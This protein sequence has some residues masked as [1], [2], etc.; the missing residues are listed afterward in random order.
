MAGI[1]NSVG[2]WTHLR[3]TWLVRQETVDEAGNL[4]VEQRYFISSLLWNYFTPSQILLVVRLHW[5]VENDAFNS[6]DLQWREDS[7]P[8]CTMGTAVWALGLLRLLAYNTAQVLR[9]RRLREKT[10]DGGI[11]APMSWRSLFKV[12]E[13]ALLLSL[14]PVRVG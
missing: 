2:A 4:E 6:L 3:Q 12:I 7:G 10:T 8:W 1:E 14:E 13:D 9:R 11:L 5:G